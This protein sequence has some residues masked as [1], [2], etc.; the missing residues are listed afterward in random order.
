MANELLSGLGYR[1]IEARR[2]ESAL[3]ILMG[4]D[5]V[6]LLFSDVVMPGEISGR[7]L[8]QKACK[9]R[10]GLKVLLTTGYADKAPAEGDG[11]THFLQKP[12]RRRDLALKVRSILDQR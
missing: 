12:Y 4:S 3:A 11:G 1:V 8:A 7:E 6:D 10:P 9:R 5:P 2:G